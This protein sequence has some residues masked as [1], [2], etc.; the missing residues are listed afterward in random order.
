MICNVLGPFSGTIGKSTQEKNEPCRMLL[1]SSSPSRAST[2][3]EH[4]LS[5]SNCI[6]PMAYAIGDVD[7]IAEEAQSE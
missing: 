2:E 5:N 3:A 1:T 7:M 6:R 4:L